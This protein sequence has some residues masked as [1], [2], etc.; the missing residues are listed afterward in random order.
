MRWHG[1][2]K[3]QKRMSFEEPAKAFGFSGEQPFSKRSNAFAFSKDIVKRS[4]VWSLAREYRGQIE[5]VRCEGES[6]PGFFCF[7]I[8]PA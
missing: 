3:K 7:R 8:L 4:K 2:C 6:A 1:H 5:R